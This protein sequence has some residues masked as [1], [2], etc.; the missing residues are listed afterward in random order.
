MSVDLAKRSAVA[1]SGW[2]PALKPGYSTGEGPAA[3]VRALLGLAFA[4]AS[5]GTPLVIGG[6]LGQSA[7]AI[8]SLLSVF[9]VAVPTVLLVSINFRTYLMYLVMMVIIQNFAVGL[10][11][12]AS[13]S[14]I[15]FVVIESKT[16]SI[17]LAVIV[18]LGAVVRFLKQNRRIATT[19]VIFYVLI[20]ISI[21]DLGVTAIAYGRNFILPVL[22]C[23]FVAAKTGDVPLGERIRWLRELIYVT[24]TVMLIGIIMEGVLGA[25]TWGDLLHLDQLASLGGSVSVK[26][27]FLGIVFN[28]S[29]GI[30]VEPTNAG[31]I[32]AACAALILIILPKVTEGRVALLAF[33]AVAMLLLMLAAAKSGLLMLL[34]AVASVVIGRFTRGSVRLLLL[35]SAAGIGLVFIYL[36]LVKGPAK[37]F[38]SFVDPI[39]IVG[40]DSTTYHWAG[41]VSGITQGATHVIGQGL[42][43]GGNFSTSLATSEET[44]FSGKL[45]V[46]TGGESAWGVLSYQTGIVGVIALIIVLVVLCKE[47]G[48]A[49]AVILSVWSVSSMFAEAIFGIQVAALLMIGA[50]LTRDTIP[51]RRTDRRGAAL[52]DAALSGLALS[53]PALRGTVMSGPA[54]RGSALRGSVLSGPALRQSALRN[55]A[56]RGPAL[57]GTAQ[58]PQAAP[59]ADP[60]LGSASPSLRSPSLKPA[61]AKKAKLKTSAIGLSAMRDAL[62]DGAAPAP[63][64][65][66][67]GTA[68]GW[69]PS[70]RPTVRK[71]RSR[72]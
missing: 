34:P 40:G 66:P 16:V 61:A 14:T 52:R 54:L 36:I 4:F 46:A 41:L 13:L 71:G 72:A 7:D 65:L 17:L 18:S 31:Y 23:I 15:P 50:A 43:R 69:T 56:F 28:R 57:R 20:L 3:V 35:N 39:G 68:P 10:W 42:G 21:R 12:P 11:V 70:L 58:V 5:Y 53:G 26:T 44:T 37:A 1:N 9:A 48:M 6:Q 38:G 51:L 2:T 59:S 29:A 60:P 49:S 64:T 62:P 30:I 55:A 63:S 22:L 25:Q 24:L 19:V 8:T 47:W 33:F 27:D 32:A 67:A 45:K